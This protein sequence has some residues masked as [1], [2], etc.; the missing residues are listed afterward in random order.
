MCG[1]IYL[2]FFL[3]DSQLFIFMISSICTGL[4]KNLQCSSVVINNSFNFIFETNLLCDSVN[5]SFLKIML[6]ASPAL[7]Q[8]HPIIS[9]TIHCW[10]NDHGVTVLDWPA[11]SNDQNPIEHLVFSA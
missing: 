9:V 5:Y 4:K 2:Y 11:N 1:L 8:A 7:H 6:S 10:F 3:L